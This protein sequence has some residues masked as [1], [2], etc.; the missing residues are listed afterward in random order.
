MMQ[1]LEQSI[2]A[3]GGAL[4]QAKLSLT[5]CTR[6]S[7]TPL[8]A[9]SAS[10]RT[11]NGPRRRAMLTVQYRGISGNDLAQWKKPGLVTILAPAEY[12]TGNGEL[13]PPYQD[14]KK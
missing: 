2:K 9:R 3:T 13:T 8:S 4:D 6:P 12:K 11:A 10:R 5:T 1:V 7:S 14:S